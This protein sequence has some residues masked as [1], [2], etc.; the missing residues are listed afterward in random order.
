M[1][2]QL[3][4]MARLTGGRKKSFKIDTG[5]L[6]Y[7]FDRAEILDE[8][9]FLK[10]AKEFETDDVHL[11]LDAHYDYDCS[12]ALF[13][14]YHYGLLFIDF[15]NRKL[16]SCN[17]HSGFLLHTS[18]FLLSEVQLW[19]SKP[20]LRD[21][22][23]LASLQ[24]GR[25]GRCD[26]LEKFLDDFNTSVEIRLNDVVIPNGLSFDQ[27]FIDYLLPKSDDLDDLPLDQKL[28]YLMHDLHDGERKHISYSWNNLEVIPA[29]WTFF[30]GNNTV[31]DFE[32]VMDYARRH[33][34]LSDIDIVAWE[35]HLAERFR[36][37]CAKHN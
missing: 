1:G 24:R 29:G 8:N 12:A 6:K 5:S 14:P 15:D 13:A 17:G 19:G 26:H 16:F 30:Q 35:N 31:E 9:S 37:S 4:V 3:T 36:I 21:G 22:R 32:Y 34:L 18:N 25:L 20:E 33:H 7:K 11:N 28:D 2:G 23:I 10:L 27:L